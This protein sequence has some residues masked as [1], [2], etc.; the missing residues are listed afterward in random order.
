MLNSKTL[1]ASS[2]S[3][4]NPPVGADLSAL[5]HP[6]HVG[7][8]PATAAPG[9]FL[10]PRFTDRLGLP[11]IF[12]G[13]LVGLIPGGREW[14]L[15]ALVVAALYGRSMMARRGFARVI[16]PWTTR[17]SNSKAN[18]APRTNWLADRWFLLLAAVASSA[19]AAWVV[20]WMILVHRRPGP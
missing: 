18:G 14:L 4:R 12:E 2:L 19:V 5:P 11:L 8:P 6:V 3:R 16:R 7:D 9:A 13:W 20:S 1:L 15:V 10:L 17:P